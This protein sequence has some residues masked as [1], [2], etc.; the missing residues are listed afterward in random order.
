MEDVRAILNDFMNG[1][2]D[3]S[4]EEGMTVQAFMSL[5]NAAFEASA[6]DVKT[7]E[8]ISVGIAAY[9][10]CKYCIVVH[11]YNAY[12]AGAPD[13]KFWTLQ[14]WPQAAS[15]RAPAWRIPPLICWQQSTNLNT[16]STSNGSNAGKTSS[17]G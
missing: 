7:K 15:A 10:R 3:I 4:K 13:R 1:V 6:L 8:L 14:W 16:I 9:N 5:Q 12:Q 11:V 2:N 17:S